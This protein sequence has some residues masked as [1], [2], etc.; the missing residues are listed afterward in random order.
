MTVEAFLLLGVMLTL[1]AAVMLFLPAMMRGTL[2][3]GVSVPA[4]RTNEPVIRR[5]IRRYRTL[6]V[7]AWLVCLIL[8]GVFS[9]T[10]APALQVACILLFVL[11]QVVA[12]IVSRQLIVR[13]K[14]DGGWYEG[15]PVRIVA[16]VTVGPSKDR[17]PVPAGWFA[18]ALLLLAGSAAVVIVLYPS[19]PATVP[20]HWGLTGHA[21]GFA[22]KGLWSVFGPLII[23][24]IV[25]SGLFAL[26]FLGRVVPVRPLP[27]ATPETNAQRAFQ[28]RA[29]MS[30]LIGRLL[31]VE[32]AILSWSAVIPWVAVGVP[33]LA[34]IGSLVGVLLIVVLLVAFMLRWRRLMRGD[35]RELA[36][37]AGTRAA[38]DSPD[39]DRFWKAG[40]FYVNRDDPAL[41]VQRRFGVGWTLNLGHPAGVAI[42]VVVL[43]IVVTVL[44]I[45]LSHVAPRG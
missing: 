30:A 21:N 25:T 14:H 7:I 1:V 39:D 15:V 4:S 45:A 3:L 16:D 18:A 43:V 20:T 9:F 10:A 11:G 32:A 40:I 27:G 35:T 44:S 8:L 6:V 23:G 37:E 2:P 13:A 42:G 38:V 34:V 36:N 41:F 28:M 22:A 31:F 24:A 29:A 17:G 19:M 12:Y 5:A 33:L 26:S